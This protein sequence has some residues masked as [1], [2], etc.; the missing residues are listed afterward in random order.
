[1]WDFE[2]AET[3]LWTTPPDPLL[4][5]VTKFVTDE[6]F[7]WSGTA[8]ELVELLGVD[9]KPNVLTL[10]LN[11]TAG[12]LLNDYGIVYETTRTHNGRSVILKRKRDDA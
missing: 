4:K 12:R 5:A 2:A 7:V 6:N 10:K 3:E 9:M 1:M 8:T 11:L